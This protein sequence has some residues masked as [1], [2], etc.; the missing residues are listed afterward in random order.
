M[1]D[2]LTENLNKI[3]EEKETKLLPENLKAGVTCLG[4]TG[5]LEAGIDT[6]DATATAMD[7]PVGVTA[8]ANGEKITGVLNKYE[9]VEIMEPYGGYV[10]QGSVLEIKSTP[11]VGN[12][13]LHG[14][15][16]VVSI[17]V[18]IEESG[19][20]AENIVEGANVFG[21]EGTGGGGIDTSDATAT[22]NDIV[23]GKTA[24]VNGEKIEGVIGEIASGELFTLESENIEDRGDVPKM[25]VADYAMTK[26]TVLQSDSKVEM[27]LN[28]ANL[29]NAINLTSDKIVSGNTILGVEGTGGGSN[30][31]T[32][33]PI[34]ITSNYSWVD[35]V[36]FKP[37]LQ[38]TATTKSGDGIS[39][40][41][42]GLTSDM[43]IYSGTLSLTDGPNPNDHNDYTEV[44][45]TI[46]GVDIYHTSSIAG[47][48]T[49]Y[50]Y[51]WV[52]EDNVYVRA[53]STVE[54]TEQ[55]AI[56][57]YNSVIIKLK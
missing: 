33:D 40:M 1:N 11:Y 53:L 42:I 23:I 41:S 31:S 18:P 50:Y 37:N 4:V 35:Y 9:N 15:G 32:G 20:V 43:E 49:F 12:P 27:W 26:P 21:V 22:A 54:W 47:S 17:A 16:T 39:S 57:F 45:V 38:I 24:Y 5:E 2:Q 56:T 19:L 25:V 30:V 55:D 28:Y 8:Y 13:N 14:E 3:L 48:T 7:L 46:D 34:V 52:R 44:F 29:A 10:N 6:S 51:R 36:L